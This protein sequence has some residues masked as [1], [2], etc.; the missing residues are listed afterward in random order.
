M[1]KNGHILGQSFLTYLTFS[2]IPLRFT[3][4]GGIG[5][6]ISKRKSRGQ[7]FIPPLAKFIFGYVGTDKPA[8]SRTLSAA[9]VFPLPLPG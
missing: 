4:V 6:I 5:G 8:S 7:I 2:L 9:N 1:L 3:N